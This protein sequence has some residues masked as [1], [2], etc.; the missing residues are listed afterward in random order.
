MEVKVVRVFIFVSSWWFHVF[1][2][3]FSSVDDWDLVSDENSKHHSDCRPA[4]ELNS[5]NNLIS[6]HIC[7][8]PE[9]QNSSKTSSFSPPLIKC[10]YRII[11]PCEWSIDKSWEEESTILPSR[12]IV[13]KGAM[14]IHEISAN[15]TYWTVMSFWKSLH[16]TSTTIEAT[17]VY[18]FP[19][20]WI[21]SELSVLIS[22][23]LTWFDINFQWTRSARFSK[24]E[25]EIVH[26][27]N[28]ITRDHYYPFNPPLDL[29]IS[30]RAIF[31]RYVPKNTNSPE[32]EEHSHCEYRNEE[33]DPRFHN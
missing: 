8:V 3:S 25:D 30:I 23:P 18:I 27:P 6:L 9:L 15:L 20:L 19:F 31:E 28:P 12:T 21:V 10:K 32:K 14:M 17:L 33:P 11:I 26:N 7:Q 2:S 1:N 16:F 13:K 22:I 5:E 24:A 29:V 4:V